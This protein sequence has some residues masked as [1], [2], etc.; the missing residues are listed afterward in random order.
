MMQ[1]GATLSPVIRALPPEARFLIS[2]VAAPDA[3]APPDDPGALDW[4]FIVRLACWHQ[5][6]PRLYRR[7][8]G[9]PP[10]HVPPAVRELVRREF[11]GR[12][13]HSTK[14]ARD[15]ARI[16][17][18][19][20]AAD[21]RVLALKGPVL[22]VQAYGAATERQFTDIDLLIRRNDLPRLVELF[23]R[24]GYSA[25]RFTAAAPDQGLFDSSEEEFT[26]PGSSGLIDVHLLLAPPYF[27]FAPS[28]D[29]CF[30]RAVAVNLE[31][32]RLLTLSPRDCAL[33]LCLHA[34]K[35]GWPILGPAC[36]I[37]ALLRANPDLDWIA[38]DAD[39]RR[40]RC[41]RM[42]LLGLWLASE[43]ADA[44]VPLIVLDAARADSSVV[45]LARA[46]TMRMFDAP[47]ARPSLFHEWIVPLRAIEGARGKLRY[48]AMRALTPTAEDREFIVL[49]GALT[50]LYY[51]LRPFRL[52]AQQGGRLFRS[53]P[54][55]V[56]DGVRR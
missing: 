18:L 33:F 36:D 41:R 26:R 10:P 1:P 31:G 46:V 34:A 25:R 3:V 48:F 11:Y 4:D 12:A 43:L 39:A 23:S 19:L 16:I 29:E 53:V 45:A 38:L 28:T 20:D 42:L 37:A 30:E 51:L 17:R 55:Q 35:H 6:L 5:L 52:L 2:C 50:P 7:V 13:L 15:L 14:L 44:P 8:A 56:S 22:A 49:P 9:D 21:I 40:L 54:A 24:D 27:P 32:A 47:G